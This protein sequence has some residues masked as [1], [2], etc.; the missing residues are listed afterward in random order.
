MKDSPEV[1]MSE[2]HASLSPSRFPALAHCIHYA[3]KQVDSAAR[4]R[5]IKIHQYMAAFLQ[6]HLYRAEGPN[7][8]P[9]GRD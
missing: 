3:P 2:H 5:G 1:S 6:R 8:H 4:E 9:D 7:E